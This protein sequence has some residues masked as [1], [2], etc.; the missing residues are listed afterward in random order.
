M[1]VCRGTMRS[2]CRSAGEDAM[3][4][5]C[6]SFLL[7]LLLCGA[8]CVGA[9][10]AVQELLRLWLRYGSGALDEAQLQN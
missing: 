3:K 7:L 4:K 2:H 10:A 5:R 6:R 9:Q 1:Q 8:L